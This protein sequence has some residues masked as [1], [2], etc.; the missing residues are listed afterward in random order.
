LPAAFAMRTVDDERVGYLPA[1]GEDP[2]SQLGSAETG[3][4]SAR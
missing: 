1:P 2:Q 3:I 4:A